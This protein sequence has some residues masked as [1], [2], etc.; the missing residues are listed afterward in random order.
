MQSNTYHRIVVPKR[1]APELM[2][3]VEDDLPIPKSGEARVKVEAAGVSG[4][5]IMLRRHWFPGFTKP[6]Y[7]PGETL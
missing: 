6:P 3:W 4:Y 1:G 7:T 2:Q 5:D